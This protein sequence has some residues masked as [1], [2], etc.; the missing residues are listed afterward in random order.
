[1]P[2]P[3]TSQFS[4]SLELSRVLPAL[5]IASIAA[6]G[7]LMKLA[8]DLSASGSDIVI[9]GASIQYLRANPAKMLFAATKL[10]SLEKMLPVSLL[11]GPGPTVM[12]ALKDPAYMPLVVQLSLLCALHDMESLADA[13]SEALR[14]RAAASGTVEGAEPVA[15]A[16]SSSL[17]GTLQACADQTASFNRESL[18]QQVQVALRVPR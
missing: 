5:E 10:S 15:I 3:L 1:M 9:E 12:R 2:T 16:S 14:L 6:G 18:I 7:A 8:R 13:L 11:S 17:K 4:L